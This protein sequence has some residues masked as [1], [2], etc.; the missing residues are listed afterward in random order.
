MIRRNSAESLF[1]IVN[2]IFTINQDY[3]TVKRFLRHPQLLIIAV[4][5]VA[6]IVAGAVTYGFDR[7]TF[8]RDSCIQY[9]NRFTLGTSQDR[10]RRILDNPALMA[11]LWAVYECKPRYRVDNVN[12]KYVVVDPTGIQGTLSLLE[13]T[14]IERT[15]F[16]RGKM[17]NWFIPISLKGSALFLVESGTKNDSLEVRLR[18]YGEGGDDVFTRILLKAVSPVLTGYIDRRVRNNIADLRRIVYDIETNPSAVRLKLNGS[19]VGELNMLLGNSV[20]PLQS[21]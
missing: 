7:E 15:Y 14:P 19:R 11:E 5:L 21:R 4:F 2:Y 12:G 18:V 6:I 9:E 3:G 17:K 20:N 1:C 13:I 10:W 8:I 16:G